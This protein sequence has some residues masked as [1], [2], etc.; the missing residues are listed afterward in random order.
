MNGYVARV[1]MSPR[2]NGESY[3]EAA[4][5][6][7]LT[8]EQAGNVEFGYQLKGFNQSQVRAYVAHVAAELRR[9]DGVILRQAE[10]LQRLKGALRAWHSDQ[11]R[12]QHGEQVQARPSA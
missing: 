4:S 12:N 2:I 11:A 3:K 8:P 7:I 9:R 10:E 5:P 6:L 1:P